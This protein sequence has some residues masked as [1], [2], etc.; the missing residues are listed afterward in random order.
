MCTN[1][2]EDPGLGEPAEAACSE[3]VDTCDASDEDEATEKDDQEENLL[4]L[5]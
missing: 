3:N 5:L 2:E 4:V 1:Q